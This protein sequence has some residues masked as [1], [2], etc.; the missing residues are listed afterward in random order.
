MKAEFLKPRYWAIWVMLGFVRLVTFLPYPLQI[1]V[2]R[3]LGLLLRTVSRRRWRVTLVNLER[4]FPE[5]DEPARRRL[6]RRHFASLGQAFIEFGMCWWGS[7]PRLKRWGTLEGLEHLQAARAKGNG[8]ILLSAHFTTLEICGRILGLDTD[9]YLMYRPNENA[10]IEEI[11]RGSRE[12]HFE[13]A[14]PR[15]DVRLMLRSL[16]EGKPVWY[17]MDQGYRGKNSEMVPFFGVPAP[18]NTALSRLAR[19]SGAPV[20]PFF[21]RRLPGLEGYKLS[22]EPALEGFPTDDPV[23]DAVRVN[24]L[25]EARI[26]EAPEQYLWSHDRFKVVPRD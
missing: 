3:V 4:C 19:T 15:N 20:V 5:L 22:I 23:A 21:S 1:G 2:G 25:L 6:A 7:G 18:T 8:V 14:I 9:L 13:R 24:K 26:R 12:R 16:K 11:M 17:A 10:L